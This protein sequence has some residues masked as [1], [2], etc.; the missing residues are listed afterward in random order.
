MHG[1]YQGL[2]FHRVLHELRRVFRPDGPIRPKL[3]FGASVIMILSA[4]AVTWHSGNVLFQHVPPGGSPTIFV[5]PGTLVSTLL[6]YLFL[7]PELIREIGFAG[8]LELLRVAPIQTSHWIGYR[9]ICAFL[10]SVGFAA[11]VISF[12]VY[13]AWS[14]SKDTFQLLFFLFLIIS[15]F[16]WLSLMALWTSVAILCISNRLQISRHALFVFISVVL[17]LGAF[18]A[19][20]YFIDAGI[21]SG[22][23]RRSHGYHISSGYLFGLLV[24][25]FLS[26]SLVYKSTLRLWPHASKPA[27]HGTRR[28]REFFGKGTLFSADHSWA[29][30]QKDLKD[31]CRNPNYRYS[32]LLCCLLMIYI[33]AASWLKASSARPHTWA[34]L[35]VGLTYVHMIPFFMSARTVSLEFR[36]LPF[37]RLIFPNAGR[38]LDFK[39][40]VQSVLN[41]LVNLVLA[42]PLFLLIRGG[43]R[44]FEPA[45][46]AG[47]VI[48]FVPVFTMLALAL[49][50]FF[51]STSTPQN[52]FGIRPLGGVIYFLL[53]ITLYSFL[54]NYMYLGTLLYSL[55]L[56][57]LTVFLYF[58][59][60]KSLSRPQ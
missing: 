53:A 1:R 45:Y 13:C 27:D 42:F 40:R 22:F 31:L 43:A 2:I 48:V 16:A 46:Y 17:V 47:C 10:R 18:W 6:F 15:C 14:F 29:V 5:V 21:W 41:S 50:T 26:G 49:G 51:P 55:F 28:V 60:R 37:Y 24:I 58:L 8:D 9:L 56:I 36:M 7:L 52:L 12:P 11:L 33:A 34:R 35:M 30:F 23:A 32:L 54:L 59:A 39:W 3:L 44:S 20:P 57:P 4:A 38:I 19:T 25:L